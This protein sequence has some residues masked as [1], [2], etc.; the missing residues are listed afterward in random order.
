MYARFNVNKLH[1]RDLS[2]D[3]LNFLNRIFH[4]FFISQV[5]VSVLNKKIVS[6]DKNLGFDVVSTT[7]ESIWVLELQSYQ[8]HSRLLFLLF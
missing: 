3:E 4:F 5:F 1:K 2:A 6:V 7:P 8:F